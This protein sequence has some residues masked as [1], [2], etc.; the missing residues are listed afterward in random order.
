LTT[1]DPPLPDAGPETSGANMSAM[2]IRRPVATTLLTL[3]MALVGVAAYFVLPVAPL[4]QVDIPTISIQAN[5][6]GASPTVVAATVA[7][8]LERQ[9]GTIADVTEMTSQSG[10]G[11]TRITLQFGLDRDINGA[12]RDVEA[13]IDAAKNLLPTSS[14][15]NLPNYRKVNPALRPILV[16]GLTSDTLATYQIYDKA[17]ILLNQA[18]SQ[19]QGVG[20]VDLGGGASPAVR[21]EM[22]PLAM[23]KYGIGTEDVRAAI[24]SANFFLAKG[25]ISVGDRSYQINTNDQANVAADYQNLIV[26]FRHNDPVRLKDIAEVID[27]PSNLQNLGLVNGKPGIIIRVTQ[28]PGANIITTVDSIKALLP[29]LQ[30]ALGP[31]IK[32]TTIVDNSTNIRASIADVETTLLLAVI[33]V[34]LVVLIFLRN[35][36]ATLIPGV[37]VT[38]SLIGTL[39]IM[40]VLHFSLDNLS[41]MSL[42]IA[43]GFVVDD[44]I[45]VLENITRHVEAGMPRMKAALIGSREV[46]FTVM[47]M[48]ISLI[49]VFIPILAM[50]GLV[51]RL[52]REFG[53]TL[54]ASILISLIVSLTATPMMAARLIDEHPGEGRHAKKGVFSRLSQGFEWGFDKILQTYERCLI[55]A[56]DN[57]LLVLISLILTVFLTVYLYAIVPKGFFPQQDNGLLI[58]MLQSDQSSS[59]DNTSAKMKRVQSIIT[60][61]PAVQASASYSS[62]PNGFTFIT[63][64]PKTE[65]KVSADQVIAR[66]QPKL[67][68][69]AGIS[70]FL[71]A[72][73]DLQVGGR[74]SGAQYQY[75]LE[76]DDADTLR[77][78]SNKMYN[79]MK[80]LP[81][82]AQVNTDQQS[83]ALETYITLD[84]QTA[85]RFG[86]TV[87]QIDTTLGDAFAQNKASNIYNPLNQ[88][89]VVMEVAQ[90]FQREPDAL[91]NIYV[92]PPS[93]NVTASGVVTAAA[94]SATSS[95]TTTGGG[96]SGALT[97]L[98]LP[99]AASITSNALTA[100]S[101]SSSTGSGSFQASA[102]TS[103]S[104]GS[105]GGTTGTITSGSAAA[106]TPANP[107]GA[108]SVTPTASPTSLFGTPSTPTSRVGAAGIFGAPSANTNPSSYTPN[109][110]LLNS[111]SSS[112][113]LTAGK[114]LSG[115]GSSASTT[116]GGTATATGVAVSTSAEQ[117]VP[118]SAFSSYAL[119]NT[120]LAVNH[121]NTS[122]AATISFNMAPGKALSDAQRDIEQ[123]KEQIGMPST[124][125]GSFQGTA[126]QYTASLASE[127]ILILAALAAVYI[128]LGMLYESYIHPLTVISSLPSAGVGAVLAMLI[129]NV[130]FTIISLIGVILL[131]GIVKKNAIMLIDFALVAEREQNLS[132]RDAIYQACILRF[133]PI[134]MTT[135]AAILGAVPLALGLGQGG[136]LRQPL[137]I[138][139]IGGLVVSQM[140]TLLTTPV[141]YLY[142]DK[143]RTRGRRRYPRGL[144]GGSSAN[145]PRRGPSPGPAPVPA[146]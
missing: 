17:D 116:G 20:E 125:V 106:S 121:Q 55:W 91:K 119:G 96:V 137:G 33:L 86:L 79:A 57:S 112:S 82:L 15:R 114:A 85:A 73:Q 123:V 12:A 67:A 81:D 120:P 102:S 113:S 13:A 69:V 43:T 92:T 95:S 101:T 100:P 28:S 141:V 58:G 23:S 118:L 107:S 142:L 70:L 129:F 36:R 3:A 63:L 105:L 40:Y 130:Q 124:V 71:Q 61:D 7:T 109:V 14:L 45:V 44:A 30:S 89:Q 103:A 60:R 78:W 110:S 18:I 22:N 19:V 41:L 21:V 52:F 26:A 46:G 34:V 146:E 2:F 54:S 93:A 8:P 138:S 39:A 132:S 108:S 24:D 98:S 84:R 99:A 117:M 62:A 94:S 127:P 50:G 35:G 42:T 80:A 134:L 49:A 27:G 145:G 56:L 51:G 128:V 87:S 32:I 6:A 83:H 135:C 68:H 72:A 4:P 65:R 5:D 66:L 76:S 133:R 143:L 139:I 53:L 11:Q 122:V 37:A 38:V 136:E 47:S 64:K 77:T 9:L 75:T 59:F 126:Q 140:L 29:Q 90:P 111:S 16:I 74:S 104:N 144:G 97:A 115:A 31:Q 25:A 1:I 48:S 131:I 88:Y 10:T